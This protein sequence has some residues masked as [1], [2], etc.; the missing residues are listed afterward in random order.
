MGDM[1]VEWKKRCLVKQENDLE[2]WGN[3]FLFKKE[4]FR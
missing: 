2:R 1:L 3:K 4:V